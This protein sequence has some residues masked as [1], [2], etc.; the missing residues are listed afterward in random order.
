WTIQG[1]EVVNIFTDG[2]SEMAQYPLN[3]YHKWVSKFFTFVIPF[4]TV[5]YLPL[6]YLLDK[7]EGNAL[8]YMLAPIAGFM[9]I[10]PCIFVEQ[11]VVGHYCSTGAYLTCRFVR[12]YLYYLVCFIFKFYINETKKFTVIFS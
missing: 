11:I 12:L 6:M 2:G 8:P 9:F 10:I 7:H 3:I 1:L 5:N 4:G